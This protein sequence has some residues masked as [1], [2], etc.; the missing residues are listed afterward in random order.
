MS[1]EEKRKHKRGYR[2]LFWPMLFIGVGTAWL[3]LNI[4]VFTGANIAVAFQLW[5]LIFVGIGLDLIFGRKSPTRGATIG[6]TFVGFVLALMY[7]GPSMGLGKSAERNNTQFELPLDGAESLD[8][9]IDAGIDNVTIRPL[10]DSNNLIEGDVWHYGEL[11]VDSNADGPEKKVEIEQGKMGISFN[12]GE[13]NPDDTGWN[14]NLNPSVALTVDFNGGVGETVMDLGS[15]DLTDVKLDMGVGSIQLTLP[16]PRQDYAVDINGGV[17]DVVLDVPDNTA[18]QVDVSTG[19]GDV[20]FPSS[21]AQIEGEEGFIGE[22]GVWQ[23]EGFESA[24][25][26]IFITFDGGVGSL[27]IR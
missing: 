7:V 23:T 3:L 1:Y 8:L 17:G 2:S 27:D 14:L 4:G 26:R 16:V 21:Y 24:T 10:D 5:P 15:F 18:V 25:N 13:E 20:N 11:T 19:V 22:D 12:L 9:T 6:L